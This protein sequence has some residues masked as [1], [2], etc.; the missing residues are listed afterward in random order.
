MKTL[1]ERRK[2]QNINRKYIIVKNKYK[3]ENSATL[4]VIRKYQ[5]INGKKK[6][7]KHK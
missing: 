6:I 5:N 1:I 4:I 3:E 7:E 2:F